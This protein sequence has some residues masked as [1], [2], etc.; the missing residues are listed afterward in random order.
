MKISGPNGLPQM[1]PATASSRTAGGT[2]KS[3]DAARVRL[4]SDAGFVSD[5]QKEVADTPM[6]R[7]DVVDSVRSALEAGTFENDIDWEQTL[8]ALATDL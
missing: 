1:A 4:S 6:V 3:N 8:D 7:K 5:V 2:P